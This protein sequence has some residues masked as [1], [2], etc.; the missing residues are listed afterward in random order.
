MDYLRVIFFLAI[1]VSLPSPAW[2]AP[3]A[4]HPTFDEPTKVES[5]E[6]KK[7]LSDPDLVDSMIVIDPQLGRQ[8]PM[9]REPP[10]LFLYRQA[11]SPHVGMG[12]NRELEPTSFIGIFY[13]LPAA[14]ARHWELAAAVQSDG[15]GRFLVLR[16]H[17][18]QPRRRIRPYY[19]FGLNWLAVASEGLPTFLNPKNMGIAALIGVEDLFVSPMSWRADLN[20][21]INQNTIAMHLSLGYSWSW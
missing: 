6:D 3:H 11:M 2:T 10:T 18:F 19:S 8:N 15:R 9:E 5:S 7:N 1:F 14:Q 17:I 4:P 20:L 16:K 13:Q 21:T 12:I